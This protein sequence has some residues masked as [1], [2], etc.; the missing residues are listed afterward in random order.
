M[1][2]RNPKDSD[3]K[4]K[5]TIY[6]VIV[7]VFLMVSSVVGFV[8]FSGAGNDNNEV[9]ADFEYNGYGFTKLN[10]GWLTKINQAEVY[11]D[12]LPTEVSEINY[13]KEEK[14]SISS[15][16]YLAYD[17]AEKD[18]NMDFILGKVDQNLRI[19]GYTTNLACIN[20][21]N[22]PDIPIVDC[23]NNQNVLL[24]KIGNTNRIYKQD[25]CLFVEGEDIIGVSKSSD[26]F[27]YSITGVM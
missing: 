11:F 20:E 9:N 18:S 16:V 8:I 13:N 26:K 10:S 6:F 12:Y 7:I 23:S 1:K 22:C 2:F 3:K 4:S 5:K 17:P 14:L 21:Q 19:L 25:G 15:K 24:I 27:I